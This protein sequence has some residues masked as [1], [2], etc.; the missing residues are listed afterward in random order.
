MRILMTG[1][2]GFVGSLLTEGLMAQG[3]D[4]CF[5]G[6]DMAQLQQKFPGKSVCDYDHISGHLQGVD[7][8]LHMAT[9]NNNRQ[10]TEEQFF[11]ANV[12]LLETIAQA[13]ADAGVPRFVNFS[14]THA[15]ED[16]NTTVYAR[17]KRAGV[18]TL[19]LLNKPGYDTIYLPMVYGF[20]W[21]GKLA[22]LN[23][24]PP[25][26]AGQLFGL[27][28]ALKP[29]V[30]SDQI[31][32]EV[33]SP[34]PRADGQNWIVTDGQAHNWAYRIGAR[35][36]DLAFCVTIIGLLFWLLIAVWCVVRFTSKGPGLFVQDRVGRGGQVF[37]CWKFRTMY[38]E[39]PQTGTHNVGAASTTRIG[40]FLRKTKIDELPQVKNL[41]CN[42]M[43]L[44]GPRPCLPTQITLVD[45][46]RDRGVLDIKPGISGLAQ[47]QNIDMSTPKKLANKDAQYVRL[48]SL[49]FD[50]KLILST[51]HGKGQG[52]LVAPSK[53]LS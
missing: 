28:A 16:T 23:A 11:K 8:V 3:H 10:G 12:T 46:R 49:L 47:V 37:K 15:L 52:D 21:A 42:E 9:L 35:F 38:L 53:P 34:S 2:T 33:I 25:V 1:A 39:T 18:A 5:A 31:L 14:S 48:R 30:H 29:T 44:I 41:L 43:S 24:L 7:L 26:L 27:L 13:A 22:R 50:I 20:K 6:R 40:A 4:L 51:A 45:M 19:A 32:R 36:L 17:S